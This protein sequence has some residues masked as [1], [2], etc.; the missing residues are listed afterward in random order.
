MDVPTPIDFKKLGDATEGS[1]LTAYNDRAWALHADNVWRLTDISVLRFQG[2]SPIIADV[3]NADVTHSIDL[4]T[5]SS[6]PP[7][8]P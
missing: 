1:V 4:N 8:N 6:V 3:K 5:L 2:V 7:S